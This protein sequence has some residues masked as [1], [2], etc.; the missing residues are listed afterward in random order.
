MKQAEIVTYIL[1]TL[2][3]ETWMNAL[4]AYMYMKKEFMYEPTNPNFK[5][6]FDGLRVFI[7]ACASSVKRKVVDK[8]VD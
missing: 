1:M 6:S 5:L 7:L 3:E 8:E 2:N 4:G